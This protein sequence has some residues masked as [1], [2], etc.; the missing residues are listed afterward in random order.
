MSALGLPASMPSRILD[1]VPRAAVGLM[2]VLLALAAASACGPPPEQP[3]SPEQVTVRLRFKASCGEF[4]ATAYDTSCLTGLAMH[5]NSES[6]TDVG[7][8]CAAFGPGEAPDD[9]GKIIFTDEALLASEARVSRTRKVVI[10]V[11]GVQ[12]IAPE[13]ACEAGQFDQSRWLFWGQSGVFDIDRDG[14][15]AII[16]V[17]IECRDC[18]M[19]C[20]GGVCRGCGA[21]AQGVCPV[22]RPPSSCV[23]DDGVCGR[24]CGKTEDCFEGGMDCDVAQHRCVP[25]ALEGGLCTPCG[26]GDGGT[27]PDECGVDF[28][29][30]G[31][32]PTSRRGFCAPV[33][34]VDKATCARGAKCKAI[35]NSLFVIGGDGGVAEAVAPVDAGLDLDAG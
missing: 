28:T 19:A 29:C 15:P 11:V 7:H 14:G 34:G 21:I 6:L 1:G 2:V 30:V 10:D 18:E 4:S 26:V 17:P 23:P 32:S 9:L 31:A 20:D 35:G 3:V 13:E 22:A 12:G 33:C 24:V 16:D 5:V 27:A 8:A 25:R